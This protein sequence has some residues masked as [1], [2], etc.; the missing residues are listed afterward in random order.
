MGRLADAMGTLNEMNAMGVQP[1]VTVYHSLI[2]GFC[3]HGDL[4]KVKELIS[5]MMKKG[6]PSPSIV[7]FSSVRK[8]LCKEGRIMDAHNI[9]DFIMDVGVKPDI[10]AFTTR[11]DGYCLVGKKENAF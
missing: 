2:Q 11:I 9:L 3:T 5:E 1:D 4:G 7:F 10:I 6:I 8:S